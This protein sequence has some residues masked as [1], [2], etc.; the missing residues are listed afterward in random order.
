MGTYFVIYNSILSSLFRGFSLQRLGE[1][2]NVNR[3]NASSH[4]EGFGTD[5]LHRNVSR[6]LYSI[7]STG[8]TLTIE[9]S[10]S[11]HPHW[12]STSLRD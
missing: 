2:R 8:Q 10:L 7:I 4:R 1:A 3:H 12:E 6:H 11:S 5:P 9:R